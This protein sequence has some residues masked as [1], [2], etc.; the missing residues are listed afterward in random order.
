M[1][2][3]ART[4]FAVLVLAL[5]AAGSAQ[6]ASLRAGIAAFNRENFTAAAT[7]LHPLADQG[8]A[9]AQSYLGFMYSTGRG[10]PQNYVASAYWYHR[11]AEQGDATAQYMLGLMYDKGQG[12]APNLIEAHKWLNLATAHAP[13]RTRDYSARIRDA[14]ATKMTRGEIG[15]ARMLAS[16]WA[17]VF[18]RSPVGAL[19]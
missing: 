5:V 14:V 15:V 1:G 6:A 3:A 17:P 4:A 12:V 9:K 7:I 19:R 2:N 10:V 8:D 11:A 16:Q 13:P 18:E